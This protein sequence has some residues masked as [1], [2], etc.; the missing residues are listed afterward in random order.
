[1]SCGPDS[2]DGQV[3]SNLVEV[4]RFLESKFDTALASASSFHSIVLEFGFN[5][6]LGSCNILD[7][8]LINM[9]WKII[10]IE[11]NH[12]CGHIIKVLFLCISL[13]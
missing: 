8:D 12:L 11:I 13:C 7:C 3:R 6:V 5:N 10:E 4:L 1:M 9:R 2:S